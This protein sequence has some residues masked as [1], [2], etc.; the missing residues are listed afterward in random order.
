MSGGLAVGSLIFAASLLLAA[1]RWAVAQQTVTPPRSSAAQ[2]A[3]PAATGPAQAA[4]HAAAPAAPQAGPGQAGPGTGRLSPEELARLLKV[5][6]EKGSDIVVP[7]PI[8]VALGLTQKQDG[9]TLKQVAFAE[10]SGVRHGFA[11][12]NDKSGYFLFKRDQFGHVTVFNVRTDFNIV[13]AASNFR[14]ETFVQIPS[15]A[16]RKDLQDELKQWAAVLSP[17]RPAATAGSP[18]AAGSATGSPPTAG[19]ATGSPSAAGRATGSPSAA[20]GSPA[21][22][23][24]A[25]K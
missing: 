21:S 13:H 5:L 19:S 16:A 9:P 15:A 8:S 18:S 6:E 1:P 10:D 25:K 22:G 4:V 3:L 14:G 11:Q 17:P 20:T 24:A 7:P 2:A 23:S 12:L